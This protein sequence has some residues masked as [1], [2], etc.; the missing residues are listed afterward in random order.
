MA[1]EPG[2]GGGG[3]GGGGTA[4]GGGGTAGGLGAFE[5]VHAKAP[6]SR[7]TTW[8]FTLYAERTIRTAASAV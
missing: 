8:R 2:G 5:S 3:G 4:G 6:M 1:K 7:A